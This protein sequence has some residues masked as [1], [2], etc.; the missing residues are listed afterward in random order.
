MKNEKKHIRIIKNRNIFGCYPLKKH[1]GSID[2][3]NPMVRQGSPT[4]GNRLIDDVNVFV[5]TDGFGNVYPGPQVPF[6]GI[7]ISPVD[8]RAGRLHNSPR[9][10]LSRLRP[11]S[12]A[13]ASKVSLS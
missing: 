7:Q 4:I 11:Q 2:V 13:T 1:L 10:L 8:R 3:A 9:F 12:P 6:G 5:G